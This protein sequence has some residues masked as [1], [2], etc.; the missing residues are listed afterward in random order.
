[1]HAPEP[2]VDDAS[3]HLLPVSRRSL[4]KGMA[5][6]GG[7]VAVAGIAGCSSS[8]KST[9]PPPTTR[10]TALPTTPTTVRSVVRKPGSRPNPTLPEGT[11][12]LAKIQHIVVV[13]MENHSFDGRFG[14]LGRGD[15]FKL[16]ASGKPLD[17]NPMK[18]GRLLQAFHMPSTCQ[19][20]GAPGQN[21]VAS[22]T[23]FDNGRNDGF[24]KASG[25]VAM[26]YWDDSD[27]PF[28]YGLA[29]TF[30]LCDRYFCST[31]AQTYPNRRF[32]IA[33]T[34]SGTVST[35]TSNLAKFPPANGT[36]L[37]RLHAHGISWRD[38]A[39]DLPGI[40]V[41]LGNAAKY[42]ATNV[43]LIDQFYKDAAAGSLPSVSFVDPRFGGDA[44]HPGESE[45]DNDDI[46]YGENFVSKVVNAVFQSPNWKN[47]VLIYTYDEH[48][49][50][51]DHVP[52]PA[53]I[54]PDNIPP[55]ADV[56]DQ[57]ITG[58]YDRYG[59]RVPT[60]IVSPFAKRNYISSQVHDHTSILKLIETKWNL[61]AL[62]YRDANASNLLDSLDLVGPP[63]FAE[64]PTLPAPGK[65]ATCTPGSP[66]GP[67]PP[68]GA[69]VPASRAS[70]LRIGAT[71]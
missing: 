9:T 11:D 57:R 52:P 22:H 3:K 71:A 35:D 38:Y 31:L 43:S 7:A 5:I 27:I 49:G 66:G 23:S 29:R 4:L 58:A 67:I 30:P 42:G 39:T 40:D 24:V 25:P 36:I 41:I 37:D 8:A 47:T 16:D 60:V 10:A 6:G 17:A 33:G 50:Y 32:L 70:S 46:S 45:E 55:G 28:Y 21:W 14:M 34:A 1:M 56:P 12:M 15:G 63:A 62:T 68:A 54:K 18:D 20:N 53:A 48:G 51:Y 61:G 69:I 2:P 44:T 19:L 26:G 13:M 64:P 65:L 59:F